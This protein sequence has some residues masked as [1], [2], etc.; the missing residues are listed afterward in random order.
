[1]KDFKDKLAKVIS[2]QNEQ[3]Q[4]QIE[5]LKVWGRHSLKLMGI[6]Q[7]SKINFRPKNGNWMRS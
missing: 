1:M 3:H 6:G 4:Q 2:T 5:Q 7:N